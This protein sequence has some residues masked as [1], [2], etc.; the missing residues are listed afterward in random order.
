M[1]VSDLLTTILSN[2]NAEED[3]HNQ[4]LGEFSKEQL[5]YKLIVHIVKN[6][7]GNMHSMCL[8]TWD[9]TND[10]MVTKELKAETTTIVVTCYALHI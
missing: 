10:V 1:S 9:A 2:L 8:T 5:P 7:N 3:I 4:V 6:A